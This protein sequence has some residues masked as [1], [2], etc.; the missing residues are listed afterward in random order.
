MQ[1]WGDFSISPKHFT[2][3]HFSLETLMP[4][5]RRPRT[6]P[7]TITRD[8]LQPLLKV[9]ADYVQLPDPPPSLALTAAAL[10]YLTGPVILHPGGWEAP[11]RLRA[12]IPAARLAVV[13]SGEREL[14]TD[15]EALAYL[16]TA[17][18]CAPLSHDWAEIF[19]YLAQ[20]VL[21]PWG[22][23]T[24]DEP[25]WQAI[26]CQA[27]I[28]LSNDQHHELRDLRRRLRAAVVKHARAR[29]RQ[30]DSP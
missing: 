19:F 2:Q 26:G 17:S 5:Q 25:V 13:M 1:T 21:P 18:L 22:L 20:A 24:T 15:E 9:L 6:V 3:P 29:H 12:V 27:P 7:E 8:A 10:R 14:A 23:A 4:S 28:T 30:I 11:E 16:S